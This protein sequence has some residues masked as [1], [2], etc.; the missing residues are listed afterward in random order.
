V[1]PALSVMFGMQV[2]RTLLPLLVYGLRD[3]VGWTAAQLGLLA[4]AVFATAFLA[5]PLWR[6]MGI[7]GSLPATAGGL[8]LLRLVMQ[9]WRG[10]PLITFGLVVAAT[11]LFGLFLPTYLLSVLP[12]GPR[13]TARYGVAVLLG[14]AADTALHGVL[15]TW[16]LVWRDGMWTIG[17]VALL[18]VVQI[19][20]LM[21]GGTGAAATTAA[22]AAAMDAGSATRA[23]AA[24]TPGVA[25]GSATRAGATAPGGAGLAWLAI[26]PVLA[27]ALLQFENISRLAALG[28]W[29]LPL[30]YDWMVLTQVAGI[31]LATWAV[32]RV[33]RRG[34]FWVAG[35][36]VG[37]VGVTAP[38]L[39]GV[40][41]A[42]F[43]LLAGQLAFALL[44][45]ALFSGLGA[46]GPAGRGRLSLANGVGMILFVLLLFL[47]YSGYDIALPLPAAALVPVGAAIL[48][49]C[50]VVATRGLPVR[51]IDASGAGVRRPTDWYPALAA[52]LLLIL[53]GIVVTTVHAPAVSPA[54]ARD[55]VRV[56]TFNIHNGF[57]TQGW[58]GLEAIARTIE[59][60]QPDVVA[61]QEAAR[62]W[63]IDGSTDALSWL[64]LRLDMPFVWDPTAG[65]LWG[66]AILSRFP[67]IQSETFPLP[68]ADLLLRRGFVRA[69]LDVGRGQTLDVLATH[70]HHVMDGSAVRVQESQVIVDAWAGAPRTV[71]AGDMNAVPGDPE[72]EMLRA[73]GLVE[74]VA[75]AGLTPGYTF[76]STKPYQRIDYIWLSPDLAGGGYGT[77]VRDVVITTGGASDHLGIA[78]TLAR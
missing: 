2:L 28:G 39:G 78:A 17:L 30:A 33:S 47:T 62:G 51:A 70:Y 36:G 44:V 52:A 34:W 68:T 63:V 49:V 37:L 24:A 50:A 23:D 54:A 27:L 11:V 31:A 8:G 42:A 38:A 66:N 29:R 43:Q 12:R 72:I 40:P 19:G 1:V 74:A 10:D 35:V 4:L 25:A 55:G 75:V 20:F 64:S 32:G 71:I 61:L 69:R 76:D 13:A 60:Q 26:G 77:S 18:V 46:G 57:D 53:P 22:P 73:A 59:Q 15:L 14:F 5:A 6:V 7:R 16:D 3:R 67:V 21:R 48:A 56:M 58:L 45:A 65:P 9:I 41:L